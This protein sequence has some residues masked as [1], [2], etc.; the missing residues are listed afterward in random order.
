MIVNAPTYNFKTESEQLLTMFLDSGSQYIRLSTALNL[1]SDLTN[2]Q[3]I[4]I[5]TFGGYQQTEASYQVSVTVMDQSN[6]PMH[7]KLWTREFITSIPRYS[8]TLVSNCA[9]SKEAYPSENI[10]V[11]I[12]IGIEYYW[13]IVDSENMQQ[14]PSGLTLVP[15]K[16]G[17]ILAGIQKYCA[18][19]CA[20]SLQSSEEHGDEDATEILV[21]QLLGLRN[22]GISDDLTSMNAEVVQQ[23]YD[24]VKIVDGF[25]YVRFPWKADCPYLPDNKSLALRRLESQ[26]AKLHNNT[27]VW[28]DYCETFQ[29]QLDAGVIEDVTNSAP[30]RHIYIISPTKAFIKRIVTQPNFASY[31]M[32]LAIAKTRHCIHQ[33]PTMLPDLCGTLLRARLT[34]YLIIAFHQIG[35]Q[36]DQRDATRFLWLKDPF[37]PPSKDNLRILHFTRVPF[38]IMV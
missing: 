7:L 4:T 35:L 36:E 24:S 13:N 23:Y 15:T 21:R 32:H 31:S 8:S 34:M 28:R 3:Q 9:T 37:K 6:K 26:Y 17:P 10:N 16:F 18:F 30:Q 2:L 27:E 25:I 11:D 5:L 12:L 1:G 33:G 14:L 38:G 19:S 22:V 20:S 29:Q